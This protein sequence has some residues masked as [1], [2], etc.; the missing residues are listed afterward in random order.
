[1]RSKLVIPTLAA[2]ISLAAAFCT[3]ASAQYGPVYGPHFTGPNAYGVIYG[4]RVFPAPYA[5]YYGE[6]VI[7]P[8][9]YGDGWVPEPIFDH[10][11]PGGI[12]PYIR[13]PS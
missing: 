4:P 1:M 3:P 10:S 12:D 7:G 9:F 11:S 13:P 8:F 6:P 5:A 2:G